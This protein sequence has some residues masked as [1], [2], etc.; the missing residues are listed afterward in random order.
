MNEVTVGRYLAQRLEEAGVWDYFVI[1][2]DF[3]KA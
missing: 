3:N 2:G 1:P